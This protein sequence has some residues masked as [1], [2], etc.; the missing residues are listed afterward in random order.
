M[1]QK[2]VGN[3]DVIMQPYSGLPCELKVFTINGV[4]AHQ[5]DFGRTYDSD[6]EGANDYCCGCMLFERCNNRDEKKHTMEKYS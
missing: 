5:G 2:K 4:S 3:K 6:R 1:I